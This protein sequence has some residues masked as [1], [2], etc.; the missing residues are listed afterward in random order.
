MELRLGTTDYEFDLPSSFCA[1]WDVFYIIST[2]PNRAH[3]GRLF[4]AIIGLTIK[5]AKCPK[6]SLSDADPIQYGGK[7][8]EWLHAQDVGPIEVL[9]VGSTVFTMLSEHIATNKEVEQAG[10]F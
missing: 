4:A 8:Q 3:L 9:S 2:N 1:V 5:G 7:M 10:N 6:Y